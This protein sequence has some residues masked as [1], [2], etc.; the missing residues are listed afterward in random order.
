MLHPILHACNLYLHQNTIP[1]L[2]TVT[3]ISNTILV[4]I[5]L[6]AVG[7]QWAVVLEIAHLLHHH[8]ILSVTSNH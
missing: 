7:G 1:V 8:W 4:S 2:V 6:T 5:F 3:G